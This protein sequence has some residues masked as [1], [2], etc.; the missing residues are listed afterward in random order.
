MVSSDVPVSVLEAMALGLPV[1]SGDLASTS[2]LVPD[3]A[4]VR[5]PPGKVDPLSEALQTLASDPV[6]QRTLG[7]NAAIAACAWTQADR[8]I[9][10]EILGW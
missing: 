6:L 3:G 10:K 5:V 2:E 1:V 8:P 9:W 7:E 4:G